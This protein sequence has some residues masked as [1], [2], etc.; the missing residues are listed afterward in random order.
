M[1]WRCYNF[2]IP[3]MCGSGF[4]NHSNK[5]EVRFCKLLNWAVN[6][7]NKFGW[8]NGIGSNNE[9]TLLENRVPTDAERWAWSIVEN[10]RLHVIL[11]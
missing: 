4:C 7:E 11:Y 9:T 8:I 10:S 3:G 1:L 6:Y 5:Q 2:I